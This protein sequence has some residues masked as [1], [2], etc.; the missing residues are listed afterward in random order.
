MI[1]T[2][3]NSSCNVFKSFDNWHGTAQNENI[4]TRVLQVKE[5]IHS[6]FWLN[7]GVLKSDLR[8]RII[9]ESSSSACSINDPFFAC[10][11]WLKITQRIHAWNKES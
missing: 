4:K 11:A 10:E 3:F 1:Y 7:I 5:I 6:V 8:R 2:L 9:S